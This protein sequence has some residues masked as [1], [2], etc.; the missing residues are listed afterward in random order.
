MRDTWRIIKGKSPEGKVEYQVSDGDV[1]ERTISYDFS[2][3]Q[4]AI[5]CCKKENED[6]FN[7]RTRRCFV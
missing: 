7:C 4:E 5:E 1:G 3:K 2:N 6:G